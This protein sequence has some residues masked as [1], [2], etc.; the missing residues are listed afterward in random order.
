MNQVKVELSTDGFRRA[1]EWLWYWRFC[2]KSDRM[3]FTV[4]L[5]DLIH[6]ADYAN[7][8]KLSK[9]YRE[10]IVAHAQWKQFRDKETEFFAQFGLEVPSVAQAR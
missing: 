1:V 4:L 7:L 9:V 5:F 6:R 8:E 3:N 2:G 10:E